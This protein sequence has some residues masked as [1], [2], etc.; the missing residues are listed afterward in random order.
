MV[1][2]NPINSSSRWEICPV[3]KE[4]IEK[5]FNEILEKYYQ[6]EMACILE[7]SFDDIESSEDELEKEINNYKKTI[8]RL[9][10]V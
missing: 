4:I 10:S 3:E 2:F 7:F 5:I 6:A 9:V 1:R 8:K